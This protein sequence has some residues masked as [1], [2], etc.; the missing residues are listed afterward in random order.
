MRF[1]LVILVLTDRQWQ[2]SRV[3]VIPKTGWGVSVEEVKGWAAEKALEENEGVGIHSIRAYD[4]TDEIRKF[5]AAN[6]EANA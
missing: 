5:V 4:F 2:P 1:V 6:P 3:E